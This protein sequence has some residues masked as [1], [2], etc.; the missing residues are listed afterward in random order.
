MPI[1][2]YEIKDV[3]KGDYLERCPYCHATTWQVYVHG[4]GQCA[5]CGKNIDECCQGELFSG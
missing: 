1:K 4:H 2:E 3:V 5:K